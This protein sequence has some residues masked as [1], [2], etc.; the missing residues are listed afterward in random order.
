MHVQGCAIEI[1]PHCTTQTI[2]KRQEGLFVFNENLFEKDVL[3]KIARCSRLRS[4]HRCGV[5]VPHSS[6]YSSAIHGESLVLDVFPRRHT[7]SGHVV[8]LPHCRLSF[9]LRRKAIQQVSAGRQFS[10]TSVGS[11][12]LKMR[13]VPFR[14]DY[15][16]ITLLIVGSFIPWLYYAFYCRAL[17]MAIYITM[18]SVLGVL[19]MIVSLWDK[20]AEPSYR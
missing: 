14:L 13:P 18:I 9:G 7:V 8:H 19:A 15:A 10:L 12:I 11:G 20:F 17:H 16:G 2:E 5:V 6:V 3:V 4:I 1:E